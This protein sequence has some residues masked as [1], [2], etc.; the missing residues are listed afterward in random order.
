VAE[1]FGVQAFRVKQPDE[2][3]PTLEKALNLGRPALVDVLIHP[4]DF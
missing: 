1:A 3:R 4:G 2:L